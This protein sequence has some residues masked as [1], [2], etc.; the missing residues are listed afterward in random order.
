MTALITFICLTLASATTAGAF[1]YGRQIGYTKRD[2][3]QLK[4]EL[5]AANEQNAQL[6][7][8]MFQMEAQIKQERHDNQR[9]SQ[10]GWDPGMMDNRR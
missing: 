3:E 6:S 4:E 10:S 5:K 9:V 2:N 8:E 7:V 1:V